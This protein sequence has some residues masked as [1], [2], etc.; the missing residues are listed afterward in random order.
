[1]TADRAPGA[2]GAIDAARNQA[3]GTLEE[4]VG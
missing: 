1:L 3:D 2:Y 4:T